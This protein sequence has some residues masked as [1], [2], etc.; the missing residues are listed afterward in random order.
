MLG[1]SPLP[2]K[3]LFDGTGA[4]FSAAEIEFLAENCLVNIKPRRKIEEIDLLSVISV[5]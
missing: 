4:Q 2:V 1:I 5:E 3:E